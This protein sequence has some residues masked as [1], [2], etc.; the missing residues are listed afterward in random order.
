MNP[1]Y[2]IF[3]LMSSLAMLIPIYSEGLIVV[4]TVSALSLSLVAVKRTLT[5]YQYSH[6]FSLIEVCSYML[7]NRSFPF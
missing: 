4:P 5:C 2:A 7:T 3:F 1:L 6:L